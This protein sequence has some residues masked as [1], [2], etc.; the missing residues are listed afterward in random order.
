MFS[1]YT[2][3]IMI[4]IVILIIALTIVGITLTKKKSAD[5][6][7]E[8][9][10]TCPDF[11]TLSDADPLI[12]NPP[13]NGMNTPSPNEIKGH[14]GVTVTGD[15][16]ISA[17]NLSEDKWTGICDKATWAKKTNILWDGVANNNLCS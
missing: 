8:F 10:N 16:K 6:F 3:V 13:T 11:W 7:P 5:P 14:N 9:Q 1:F 17:I 2:I 12:C 4:A 15:S